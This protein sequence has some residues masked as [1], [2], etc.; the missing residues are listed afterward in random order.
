MLIAKRYN[1]PARAGLDNRLSSKLQPYRPSKNS[2]WEICLKV[3]KQY[4]LELIHKICA[5]SNHFQSEHWLTSWKPKLL[6]RWSRWSD[7]RP[8]LSMT[9][10]KLPDILLCIGSQASGGRRD[11]WSSLE[12]YTD[13]FDSCLFIYV[14]QVVSWHVLACLVYENASSGALQCVCD[15]WASAVAVTSFWPCFRSYAAMFDSCVFI[16]VW[17][18][19]SWHDLAC[20]CPARWFTDMFFHVET[21]MFMLPCL[22]YVYSYMIDRCSPDMSSG[23]EMKSVQHKKVLRVSMFWNVM[24]GITRSKVLVFCCRQGVPQTDVRLMKRLHSTE[25]LNK[26]FAIKSSQAYNTNLIKADKWNHLSVL[27]SVL[28]D[29]ALIACNIFMLPVAL[30]K[31]QHLHPIERRW[32]IT[33]LRRCWAH[34]TFLVR[35]WGISCIFMGGH[36]SKYWA[37]PISTALRAW[38]KPRKCRRCETAKW[39]TM[40]IQYGYRWSRGLHCSLLCS[41]RERVVRRGIG[42]RLNFHHLQG[43][44]RIKNPV[45]YCKASTNTSRFLFQC[46]LFASTTSGVS[47]PVELHLVAFVETS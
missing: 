8:G 9:H 44:L 12:V 38:P 29:A 27:T 40:R 47:F 25:H 7:C 46:C 13:M 31:V 41:G 19:E 35:K 28:P 21:G 17:Q 14:W 34:Q 23:Q 20:L 42:F 3:L 45:K 10:C 11:G 24:V 18:V 39:Q 15:V 6:P 37:R 5:K 16:Y 22:I 32:Q 26:N 36:V 4:L 2:C 33:F 1:L 43:T 30:M